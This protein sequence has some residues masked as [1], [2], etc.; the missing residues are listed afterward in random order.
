MKIGPWIG[1]KEKMKRKGFFFS[2]ELY[3]FPDVSGENRPINHLGNARVKILALISSL[4]LTVMFEVPHVEDPHFFGGLSNSHAEHDGPKK[5]DQWPFQVQ[6][7]PYQ[8]HLHMFLFEAYVRAMWSG[9]HI[10]PGDGMFSVLNVPFMMP[11]QARYQTTFVGQFESPKA[12]KI[13]MLPGMWWG[14]KWYPAT[15]CLSFLLRY[16]PIWFWQNTHVDLSQDWVYPK[17][18]AYVCA[19]EFRAI[20]PLNLIL[21]LFWLSMYPL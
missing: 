2:L 17:S 1:L 16:H 14:K 13:T 3:R 15:S 19:I 20:C 9:I 5:F 8:R 10:P 4:V 7:P 18:F 11:T 6:V 21:W 12:E